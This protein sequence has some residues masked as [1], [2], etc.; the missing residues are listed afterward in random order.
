M[1]KEKN[2]KELVQIS[3]MLLQEKPDFLVLK[4]AIEALKILLEKIS[5]LNSN[6]PIHSENIALPS[7]KAIGPKWA[8]MCLE[9]MMRTYKF[10][11][12][13]HQAIQNT[14]SN[15]PERPAT[16]L[17]VG[18]GPYATLIL[19]FLSLYTPS[20]LQLFLLEVNSISIESL[21]R[22]INGFGAE[23]YIKAIHNCD[24][25]TFIIPKDLDADILLV[26]CLQHA[27]AREPQ[28]SITYNLLPQMKK[29]TILIPE[30]ISLHIAMIDGKKKNE[31]QFSIRDAPNLD[32][33][34]NSEAVFTLNKA[35]VLKNYPSIIQ[36]RLEFPE[37]EI[38]FS[39]EQLK[40]CD[41]ISVTTEINIFQNIHLN[42]YESG[43]TIP[44][45]L[46]NLGNG[47]TI[48]GVKT[49]YKINSEPGLNV[50][51]LRA[52]QA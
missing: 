6:A 36:E 47:H 44:L 48:K 27:L 14:R 22:V 11:K 28:V 3:K 45:L 23:E 10:M 43:L 26:E 32:Y 24:A 31:Y 38:H 13:I 37:K 50:Q 29:E 33:Y 21:K 5:G 46:A 4:N 52:N 39:K 34:E 42:I 41:Q 2:R 40:N 1:T 9:D 16:I 25:S 7:G 51:F 30:N 19:P 18:T 49:Q 12:G 35:E 15:Y 20:E 8:A 17:Y